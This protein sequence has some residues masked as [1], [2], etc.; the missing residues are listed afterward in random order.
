MSSVT[1]DTVGW[2]GRCVDDL[3]LVGKAYRI[4]EDKTPVHVKGLRVGLCRSPA[5]HAIEPGGEMALAAAAERLAAE[6]AIVEELVLPDPFNRLIEAQ[7]TIVNAEGGVSFLPEYVNAHA[8]LAP[9]LRAKV[10]NAIGTTPESLLAAYT[11]ADSCRPVFDGLFGSD[12]DV[13]LTPSSPGEAPPGLHT[14]GNAIFNRMWTLL[15]VPNVGIPSGFGPHDLP[16][17]VTLVGKRLSEARQMAIAKA[18]API[19]DTDADL[20]MRRLLGTG[21]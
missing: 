19:I 18:L 9:D 12:L 16:V 8:I 7:N 13:V 2:Y 14:T 3:I 11:L 4:E 6:G 10:D 20:R 1:L 5:W 21:S 15:H 17:G